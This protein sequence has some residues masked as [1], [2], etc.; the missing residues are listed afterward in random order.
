MYPTYSQVLQSLRHIDAHTTMLQ[1]HYDI[2]RSYVTMQ[3]YDWVPVP[4]DTAPVAPH[5][6]P[7]LPDETVLLTVSSK[8]RGPK[9]LQS[10][11]D[12]VLVGKIASR[13]SRI[14]GFRISIPRVVATDCD[15]VTVTL[16]HDGTHQQD[17]MHTTATYNSE[18]SDTQRCVY[19]VDQW[20]TRRYVYGKYKLTV[21]SP[22]W[23]Y[24]IS[25]DVLLLGQYKDISK[26]QLQPH[27]TISVHH[28][29]AHCDDVI[30]GSKRRRI[31]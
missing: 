2:V 15:T 6:I 21:S 24:C 28:Y 22:H 12:N 27:A 30:P 26:W 18:M 19:D 20:I 9:K 8:H 17:G 1:H 11:R 13:Q 23:A 29:T 14:C 7:A 31:H 16:S 10:G 3:P 5:T 25:T 4:D